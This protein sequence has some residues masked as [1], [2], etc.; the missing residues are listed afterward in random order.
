MTGVCRTFVGGR[1]ERRRAGPYSVQPFG[2]ALGVSAE[3]A[4]VDDH[5]GDGGL[6]DLVQD[7]VAA[8]VH[9]A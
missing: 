8:D 1:K 5:D 7:P 4:D 2:R 9:P 6:G 3:A